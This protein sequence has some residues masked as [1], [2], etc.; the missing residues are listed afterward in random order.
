MRKTILVAEDDQNVAAA[1]KVRLEASGYEVLTVPDG[2]RC[3]MTAASRQPDLVLM[4]LCMPC[5]DGLTVARELRNAGLDALPIILM[6][7]S[8]RN[9]LWEGAQHVGAVGVF[10]KPLDTE[11]LLATIA[12]A[13]D[14][15]PRA[16]P[17]R[18]R[19]PENRD[20]ARPS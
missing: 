10:P 4:D 7:A 2:F 12:R 8:R 1:L 14:A 6:T 16:A 19:L 5:A 20:P 11:R 18:N 3:F 15:A 17:R 9:S 13:L